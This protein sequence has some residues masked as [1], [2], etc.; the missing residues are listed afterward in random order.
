MTK[1]STCGRVCWACR[2]CNHRTYCEFCNA[3]TLHGQEEPA[4]GMVRPPRTG[5]GR[6]F[7]VGVAFL[8]RRGWSRTYDVRVRSQGITGALWKGVREARRTHLPPRT[9]V[10]QVRATAVRA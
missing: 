7:V 4:A 5:G 6:L 1:C 3:C 8:T 10:R 9:Q 2:K